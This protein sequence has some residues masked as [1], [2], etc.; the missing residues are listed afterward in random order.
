MNSVEWL[1]SYLNNT[2]P[3]GYV[4]ISHDREF[5][6]KACQKT[7]EMQPLRPIN[8]YS[9]NYT[10]Y[11]VQREKTESIKMTDFKRQSDWLSSQEKLVDRFRA[12]SRAGWAKSR[13]KMLDKVEK[14]EPPFI[15][16]K[17]KFFFEYIGESPEKLLN[18]KEVFIGRKEP[19]FYIP[20]VTLTK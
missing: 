5:L 18:F 20:D 6:D 17:P 10:E 15:A 11:V 19:L 7:Y 3:S 14:I 2:W 12:G 1:E 16:K 9:C 8:I 4:I 13:E